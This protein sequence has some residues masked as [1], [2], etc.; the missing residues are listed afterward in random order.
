MLKFIPFLAVL[1]RLLEEL[2]R[3]DAALLKI[4]LLSGF[5][6][7]QAWRRIH[8]LV[9]SSDGLKTWVECAEEAYV[10]LCRFGYLPTDINQCLQMGEWW[11]P[12]IG[13]LSCKFNANSSKLRCAINPSGPCEGCPDF[14]IRSIYP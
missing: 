4:C 14:S 12:G 6:E 13:D 8:S 5:S 2:R 1:R 9:K 10:F 11:E 3:G 7:R